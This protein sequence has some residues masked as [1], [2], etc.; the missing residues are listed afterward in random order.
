MAHRSISIEQLDVLNRLAQQLHVAD[1]AVAGLGSEPKYDAICRTLFDARR[2][3]RAVVDAV[4]SGGAL[5]RR[6]DRG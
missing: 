6:A 1:L 3:L 4:S 2:E 5:R